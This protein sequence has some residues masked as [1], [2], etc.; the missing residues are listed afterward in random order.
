RHRTTPCKTAANRRAAVAPQTIHRG[1]FSMTNKL[2][3]IIPPIVTPFT[4]EGEIDEAAFRQVIQ[5][6]LSKGVHGVCVGGSSGEGHT[7]SVEE[8]QRLMTICVEEVKG[9]V[10]VV[11]GIIVNSTRDAIIRAKAISHL[12]VAGLQITPVHY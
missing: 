5:F 2:T 11:A 7:L 8:F 4:A 12:D 9:R 6:T 3:G 10:P 1:A